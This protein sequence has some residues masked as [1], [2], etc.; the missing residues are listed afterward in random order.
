MEPILMDEGAGKR[1]WISGMLSDDHM[2]PRFWSL[3]ALCL[4]TLHYGLMQV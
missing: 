4:W 2:P 1:R 3:A